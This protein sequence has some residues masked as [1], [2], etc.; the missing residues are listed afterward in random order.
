MV[1]IQAILLLRIRAGFHRLPNYTLGVR[2]G[3]DSW[4]WTCAKLG[5]VKLTPICCLGLVAVS[6]TSAF[7]ETTTG[8]DLSG[9]TVNYVAPAVAKPQAAAAAA[10]ALTF[11]RPKIG[12]R[13]GG[14][15]WKEFMINGGV[16]V[17]FNVPFIPLPGIR[18][19]GEVFG[20]PS[21]FGKDRRG[22]AFSILGV[23]TFMLGYAGI[24]PTYY[25]TDDNGNHK[26]GLGAKLLAGMSLPQ[27]LY[28]EAGIILGPDQPPVFFSIGTRF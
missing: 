2:A 27:S 9:L 11:I 15:N 12:V 8:K 16:D 19:D 25:F 22:N 5:I 21:N 1:Q 26:S 24:G 10:A 3:G 28:V 20:K 17:T 14:G 6:A 23:Q 4:D 7:S 18:V 13:V